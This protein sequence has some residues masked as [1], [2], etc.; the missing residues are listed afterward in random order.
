M[1]F[2]DLGLVDEL[3]DALDAMNIRKP[4]PI[5][6]QAIPIA[7]GGHDLI[8]CAQTGTGKTAAFVLPVMNKLFESNS[9]GT[10]ALILAPTRELAMQIDQQI[11]GLSYF[12]S[13]S[14]IAVYGGGV[15][16]VF[17]RQ[18]KAFASGVDII[19]ATPGRLLSFLSSGMLKLDQVKFLILDEADR[20]LDMGFYEDIMRIISY[21]PKERQNLMF[22]ATMSPRIRQLA[23]SILKD[24]KEVSVAIA[25]PAAG[26]DQQ[27]YLLKE[28]QKMPMLERILSEEKY[29]SG[30]IFSSRKELVK[31][32]FHSL[33]K[34]GFACQSFHSDLEQNEREEIMRDFR[35]RK[36]R[37]LIGTDVLSRGI[38]V[39]GIDLVVN[40]DA[41]PDAEDYV[42][43]I[44]RTARAS[45]TGT[46]ITFID[47]K[48]IRRFQRIEQLIAMKVK[49]MPIPEELGPGIDENAPVDPSAK[50]KRPF[51]GKKKRPNGGAPRTNPA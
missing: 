23:Q 16:E 41:P 4:T 36:L 26:I 20:M 1:D 7:L 33:R 30:I 5:Q 45:S 39:E 11:E 47:A 18:R 12:V 42:H 25:K 37:Y 8:A 34:K 46:A 32:L 38:D 6:Q 14:S 15:G 51:K 19:V 2:Y 43:R 31:Q 44:G 17:D 50:K 49:R 21:L 10:R 40:Y 22:S 28:D 27:V 3:L 24:P 13:Q 35:N 29:Q 9:S 48:D